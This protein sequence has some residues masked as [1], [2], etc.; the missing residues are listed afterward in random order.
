MMA[1]SDGLNKYFYHTCSSSKIFFLASL[2]LFFLVFSLIFFSK[3]LLLLYF[4]DGYGSVAAYN[5]SV[6][7]GR[8]GRAPTI[9]V[10]DS[11]AYTI[12]LLINQQI[13]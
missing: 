7:H 12:I 5:R 8:I 13:H 11:F 2:D 9:T 1:L 10:R 4:T 3:F 6:V